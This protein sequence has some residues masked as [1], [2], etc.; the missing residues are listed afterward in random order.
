M[1]RVQ[2]IIAPG[3]KEGLF[4]FPFW[5]I[6]A[7]SKGIALDTYADFARAINLPKAIKKE[8][9]RQ[10]LFFWFPA[11]KTSPDLFLRLATLL[12][13]D[14]PQIVN[15][16]RRIW[17]GRQ[18]FAPITLGAREAA[19]GLMAALAK[20][21]PKKL[22]E[23]LPGADLKLKNAALVLLP[24]RR[25]STEFIEI[26]LNFSIPLQLFPNAGVV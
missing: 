5:R 19:N 14:Q 18:S 15:D 4:Y 25:N 1:K 9:E 10:E 11:F 26:N 17:T 2:F 7:A 24:F 13:I 16:D 21:A 12:T 22:Y 3:G 23:L 8:W 20:P 6:S